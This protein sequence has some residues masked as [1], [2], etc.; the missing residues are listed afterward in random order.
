[1]LL[2]PIHIFL[3]L[4][5]YDTGE[6]EECYEVRDSHKTIYYIRQDPDGFKLKECTRCYQ[7]YEDNAV[8]EHALSAEKIDACTLTIVI[9]S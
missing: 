2:T 8:W 3:C 4:S 5:Y 9:P 7:A 6:R 1:M